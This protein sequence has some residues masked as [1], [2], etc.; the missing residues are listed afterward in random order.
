MGHWSEFDF[1]VVNDRFGQALDELHEIIAGRGEALRAG[2]PEVAALTTRLL[3][4]S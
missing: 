4:P 2:R 3:G 1:V